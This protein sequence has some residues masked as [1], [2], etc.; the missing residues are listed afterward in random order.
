MVGRR[1]LGPGGKCKCSN[2]G[3]E[4]VHQAGKP[5]MNTLCPNC[6][7]RMYRKE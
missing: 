7:S 2:C 3:T 6:G 5:C 4:I 1:N